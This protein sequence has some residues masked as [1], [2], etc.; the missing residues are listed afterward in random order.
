M[1]REWVRLDVRRYRDS[2]GRPACDGGPEAE[3]ACCLLVG[4]DGPCV[5]DQYGRLHRDAGDAGLLR[6]SS[7]CPLFPGEVEI[8]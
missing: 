3:A 2:K 4:L 1:E 6:P 8:S 7:R 5:F